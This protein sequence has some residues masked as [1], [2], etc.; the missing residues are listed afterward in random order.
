MK[1]FL[2]ASPAALRFK[3]FA[4]L[5]RRASPLLAIALGAVCAFGQ[6]QSAKEDVVSL[7]SFNVTETSADR[8]RAADSS[9]AARIRSSLADTAGSI[10]VL[11]P[12][13]LQD[14]SPTR[15]Y[16]ATRYVAGISEGRG[17][18]FSD[19]VMIRGFENLNR[20]VDNFQ[21][22]QG[23]NSDPLFIDRI[24]VVKGPSAILSP[25]GAPG[26]AVNL[27]SKKPLYTTQ[28]SLAVTLG[29]IDAQRADLDLTGAFS[30]NSPFAYRVLGAYQDGQLASSGTK[31]KKKLIGG[32]FSYKISPTT[33][34][35]MRASYEDRQV[36]VYLPVFIDSSSVN[37]A[38]AVLAP[39]FNYGNNRNGTE[40]W[41]HRGGRYSSADVLL[42]T[43]IGDHLSA[44]FA[45][46]AQYNVQRD[47]FM[48]ASL[49]SLGNRYNPTTGQQTPDQTWATISPG[50]F[51][52]TNSPYF[53]V[54]N[55]Q[56]QPFLPTG[57]TQ[58]YGAQYDL[59]SIYNLGFATSTTI[60]GVS[61]DHQVSGSQQLT[62]PF[63][64]FNLLAPVYGAQPVFT[65]FQT[66]ATSM[67]LT[68]Q[69]YVNEQLGFLNDR[70][71]LTLGGVRVTARS[72]NTNLLN[73][74]FAHLNDGKGVALG[75]L[76]VKPVKGV[77]IYVSRSSNAAPT[78]ANSLPLW[79]QGQ[80]WEFGAKLGLLDDRLSF[81]A[82]HFQI[83]Q[84]N[85][86]VP[87]P[88]FQTDSTQPQTLV[89]NLKNHGYEFEVTGGLTKNLSA[90]ASA[91]FL[92]MSD[93]LGRPVRAVAKRNAALFLNYRFTEGELKGFTI[94]GGLTHTGRRA[95][96]VAAINFTSARAVAQP[97]FFLAP[98]TLLNLGARYTWEKTTFAL[99]VDN[100]LNKHYIGIPTARGNAG[101][102]WPINVRLTTT[103]RF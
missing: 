65:T 27:A 10:S 100:A 93:A 98:I 81:T 41:A 64:P 88:A 53:D 37:G 2:T 69:Y 97:S 51:V 50:V 14:V 3:S 52:P 35:T 63:L 31:D 59:A 19:R 15:L 96:E 101:L 103:Y 17:D 20:T 13:F 61:L 83:A 71:L 73:G 32:Q 95:G 84:T 12:E 102:G 99:N 79:Q 16:D 60:A 70:V 33:M 58:D 8:Y 62:G 11:T 36:F 86:T 48:A 78:I 30:A 74:A 34:L 45:A 87:N 38:D 21:S 7:P 4:C 28:R 85:V 68:W 76:V 6:T 67:G 66:R 75:G 39:G 42:T 25:T 40:S 80:Q 49:P 77:S 90:V 44:R 56:R 82:A 55:I 46:K 54:T 94:F 29:L 23:E 72:R 9:S 43:T 22:V 57:Q 91:T 1:K 47:M 26:G 92:E 5:G 89:S 18:G 24:E